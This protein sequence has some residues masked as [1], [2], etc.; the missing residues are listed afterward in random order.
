[1]VAAVLAGIVVLAVL[2]LAIER[3][4]PMFPGVPGPT[5]P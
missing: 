3:R 2:Y 5:L 1:V 4:R